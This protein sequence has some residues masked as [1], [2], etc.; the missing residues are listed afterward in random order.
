MTW[1]GYPLAALLG[2]LIASVVWTLADK[3]IRASIPSLRAVCLAC[4]ETRS[5]RSWLPLTWLTNDA[6]C[7]HCGDSDAPERRRW[8]VAIAI[9]AIAAWAFSSPQGFSLV[10]AGAAPLLLIL[11]IDLKVQAVFLA[12]CYVAIVLGVFL[13][14]ADSPSQAAGAALGM[15]IAILVT[16]MFLVI[17]RWIFRSLGV[18]TTPIG[19]T[20][21]YVAAAVGAI[22]RFDGLLPALVAAV[23]AAAMYGVVVPVFWPAQRSR[24]AAFGPFLCVGGLISLL[25]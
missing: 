6:T 7:A 14:L 25:L 13:G 16:T 12:D 21:V 23:T 1:F 20:D 19:L 18:R 17:A 15:G 8:E 22:V 11:C 9:Y 10:L 4:G 5:W 2:L 24:L 3:Q